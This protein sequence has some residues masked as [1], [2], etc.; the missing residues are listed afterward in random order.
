[1]TGTTAI[2]A[3]DAISVSNLQKAITGATETQTWALDLWLDVNGIPVTP[4][5]FV[6][7]EKL[8]SAMEAVDVPDYSILLSKV[9]A[10][11]AATSV[12]DVQNVVW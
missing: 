6:D 12:Y 4:F 8:A 5:T 1:M 10:V 11:S 2:F 9:S 3:Q 7:L